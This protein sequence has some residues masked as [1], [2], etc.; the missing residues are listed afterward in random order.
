MGGSGSEE[1]MVESEVGDDTLIL[2][3]D[4]KY[5]ANVEKAACRDDVALGATESHRL[6]QVP[7]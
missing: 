1:F 2:C 6:L 3:P 5:A 4:C 7:P